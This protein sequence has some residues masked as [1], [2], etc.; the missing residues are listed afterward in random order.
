ML[1]VCLD[2]KKKSNLDEGCKNKQCTTCKSSNLLTQSGY[3]NYKK[4]IKKIK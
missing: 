3:N 4:N 1:Y 2:C